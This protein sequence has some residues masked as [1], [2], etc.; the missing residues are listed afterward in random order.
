[1]KTQENIMNLLPQLFI[2]E[3]CENINL[4]QNSK[5]ATGEREFASEK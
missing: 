3:Y 5:H 4:R 2:H 1:M